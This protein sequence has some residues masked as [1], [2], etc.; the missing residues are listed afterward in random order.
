[1]QYLPIFVF[2]IFGLRLSYIDAVTHR[3][4]NKLVGSVSLILITLMAALDFRQFRP[5]LLAGALYFIVF[6]LLHLLS[7]NSLGLGDVKYAFPCGLI[8]GFYY[9]GNQIITHLLLN[10]WLIF[11]LAGIWAL[12]A[13]FFGTL[14]LSNRIAFGPF[15]TLGVTLALINSLTLA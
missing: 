15:M 6:V 13:K 12:L 5:A 4:P 7:A 3:L 8:C 10:L 14:H 1:M 9:Y 11:G 2:V